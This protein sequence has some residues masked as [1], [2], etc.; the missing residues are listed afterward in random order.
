L[1]HGRYRGIGGGVFDR[2]IG[3]TSVSL[4]SKLIISTSSA[5]NGSV[6]DVVVVVL[7]VVVVVVVVV[8]VVVVVVV[9]LVVEVASH[10]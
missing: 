9:V 4:K 5:M 8:D 6:V 2:E 7:V 3:S 10:F 1:K